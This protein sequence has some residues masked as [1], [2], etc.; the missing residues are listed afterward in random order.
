MTRVII[1]VFGLMTILSSCRTKNE[2]QVVIESNK[3]KNDT[4]FI[5]EL[6]T[7]RILGKISL[8]N[9][10]QVHT[11]K[12]DKTTLGELTIS[13]IE[14]SY[15]TIL[16]PG[17]RKIISLDSTSLTT[18][19]SIAD[20]LINYLWS[21]TNKMFSLHGQLIFGQD[22]PV[23]VKSI[24]DS[25][26]ETRANHLNQFRT[27]LTKD[28]FGILDYQNKARAYSF[29]MF[30]GRMLKQLSPD[31]DF[32]NFIS[33]I[34]SENI[35]SK[36]LPNNLLYKYEIQILRERDSIENIDTFLS[37]IE[38]QTTSKS[39]QNF[40]K[41]VYIKDVIESPS[42]WRRHVNLFTTNTIKSAL[43]RES[44]NEYTY[45]INNASTSFYTSQ[46]GV[47]GYDFK[48]TKIDGTEIKLSDF[49]GKIVFIDTWATWCG[50]CISQ[51]P[52]VIKLA[53]KYKN[54]PNIVFLMVS[55]DNSID[56]WKNF[57]SKTN[58]NSYGI[59]VN[60]PDGMSSEFSDK[61]LIKAIPKY[62]LID[63]DGIIVDSNLSEPST[64]TELLIEKVSEKL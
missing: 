64:E 21:S 63:K 24:F 5:K 1:I 41:A 62:I 45:L 47:K 16:E 10:T 51:R 38:T 8:D 25:L 13:G 58:E 34:E 42:Y 27:K 3:T 52:N 49:K 14:I 46:K 33:D 32:F 17:G 22:N 26:I 44:K 15:L 9:Q 30:Y 53:E 56:R 37:F 59:E 36:S 31:N 2:F 4:L 61:Y 40:L 57:V 60:I 23:K 43:E 28:E 18:K 35:Y 6:I 20:S 55:I 48:A 50:P 54:N 7:E 12:I 39:L 19:E 11:F 29:L